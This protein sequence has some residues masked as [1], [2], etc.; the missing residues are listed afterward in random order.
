M[1]KSFLKFSPV[2]YMSLSQIYSFKNAGVIV[3]HPKNEEILNILS[4]FSL[5]QKEKGTDVV[6]YSD[7]ICNDSI[8]RPVKYRKYKKSLGDWV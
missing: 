5:F 1:S 7:G 3:N 8:F 6:E 4:Y 2:F